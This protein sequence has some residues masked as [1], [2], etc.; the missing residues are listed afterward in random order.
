MV[1]WETF[2]P[3]ERLH[4]T[5]SPSRSPN[6]RWAPNRT[7]RSHRPSRTRSVPTCHARLADTATPHPVDKTPVRPTWRRGFGRGVGEASGGSI[8]RKG[9]LHFENACPLRPLCTDVLDNFIDPVPHA[10]P[11]GRP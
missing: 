3:C 7:R 10:G 6:G 2:R 1:T 9:L 4:D 11:A 5:H 8:A